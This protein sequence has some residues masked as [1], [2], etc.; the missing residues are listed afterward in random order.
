MLTVTK[1]PDTPNE[2]ARVPGHFTSLETARHGVA[3]LLSGSVN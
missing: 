1:W 3:S 2:E